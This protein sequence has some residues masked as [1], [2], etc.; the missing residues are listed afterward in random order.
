MRLTTLS[1]E[2]GGR[3]ISSGALIKTSRSSDVLSWIYTF[4]TSRICKLKWSSDAATQRMSSCVNRRI[5][6]ALVTMDAA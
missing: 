3:P 2:Q 6:S 4:V 5:V 1:T